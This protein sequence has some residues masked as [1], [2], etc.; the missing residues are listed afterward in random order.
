MTKKIKVFKCIGKVYGQIPKQVRDDDS[1]IRFSSSERHA[2]LVSASPR[3]S[4]TFFLN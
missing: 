4:L 2:E 3:K 1:N